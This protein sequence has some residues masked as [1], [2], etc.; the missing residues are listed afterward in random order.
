MA[1][2]I[3]ILEVCLIPLLGA[4]TALLIAFINNKTKEIQ[5]K[6]KTDK[7]KQYIEFISDVVVD[8]VTA[9]N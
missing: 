8:C 4:L 5:E 6:M 2:V 1:I 7:Q 3:Q 9:T